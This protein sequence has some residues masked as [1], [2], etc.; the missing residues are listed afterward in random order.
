MKRVRSQDFKQAGSNKKVIVHQDAPRPKPQLC[1]QVFKR[2]RKKHNTNT[3][4]HNN[5]IIDSLVY[6]KNTHLAIEFKDEI[7]Y[8]YKDEYLKR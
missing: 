2:L 5:M 7:L 1:S 8:E 3:K 6:N 4:I